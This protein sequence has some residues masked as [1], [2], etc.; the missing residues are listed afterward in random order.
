[1][2][3]YLNLK[4]NGENGASCRLIF[5]IRGTNDDIIYRVKLI[6]KDGEIRQGGTFG[7]QS[8]DEITSTLPHLE[9]N[10]KISIAI[11]TKTYDVK[12]NGEDILPRYPVNETLLQ[13]YQRLEI[14]ML[15]APYCL[16]L[17]EDKSYIQLVG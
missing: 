3:F 17:D 4:F 13:M 7:T 16:T 15:S 11:T 12:V 2:K 8:S 6:V 14:G 1:M 10:N 5:K 9:P